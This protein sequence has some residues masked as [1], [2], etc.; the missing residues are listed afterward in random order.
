MLLAIDARSRAISVGFFERDAGASPGMG[1]WLSRRRLGAVPGRSADEYAL[2][3]R[4]LSGEAALR[5]DAAWMS[6]VAP[7]LGRELGRAVASAFGLPCSLVGPG[8][9]TGVKIRTDVPSEVGSDLV[10]AAAAAKDLVGGPC[11]IVD[12][13]AAIAFRP[14]G[15]R[16][17]FSARPSLRASAP[18]RSRF[19][20]RPP[21]CRKFFWKV[22]ARRSVR[23]PRS[24]FGR[25]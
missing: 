17:T 11:V 7:S 14:S 3:L 15:A 24:R 13:D 23:T 1:R 21:S 10:C 2:L 18:R 19:A 25:E 8:V 5:V 9:R 6:S 16:A 4:S 22:P 12:F 20:K